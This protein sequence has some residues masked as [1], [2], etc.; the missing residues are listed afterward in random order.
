MEGST[1]KENHNARKKIFH[2]TQNSQYTIRNPKSSMFSAPSSLLPLARRLASLTALACLLLLIALP[3]MAQLNI[4]E[5]D[6]EGND[7][8]RYNRYDFEKYMDKDKSGQRE[9]G[10]TS[11]IRDRIKASPEDLRK[12]G[13]SE[14]F[15]EQL[16]EYNQ[17]LDSLAN[18][19]D[20]LRRKEYEKRMGEKADSLSMD[21]IELL[22]ETQKNELVNKALALPEP[23]VYGHAFFRR[24]VHK[25]FDKNLELDERASENYELGIGDEITVAMW[26]AIDFNEAFL[27]GKNGAIE[28]DLVGRIYLRGLTYENAKKLIKDRFSNT[29]DLSQSNID[30]TLTY[31]RIIS[32][33]FAG[34]LINAGS[35]KLPALTSVFN[36]LVAIDGPN[37]LGSVRNI[38]VRRD[39]KII[40]TFDVYKYLNDPDGQQDFFL[41][42]NDYVVVSTI[43][44]VVNISGEV[45]RPHNYEI[46]NNEGLLKLIEFAGGLK[47]E[48]FTRN[49]NIKRYR[50]NEEVLVDVNL[51]SLLLAK[52]DMELMD[53]DSVFVYRVPVGLRN[54]VEVIGAVNVPGRYEVSKGDR[55]ADVL[56]KTKGVHDEADLGRAYVLRLKENLSKQI[57][58]FNLSK[59]LENDIN[60][61][62][63]LH[64]LDTLQVISRKDFRQ[65]F[66][67][68]VFGA[69]NHPGEFEYAEGLTLKDMIYLAGGM[70][71]EAASERVEV[72]RLVNYED[73][74]GKSKTDRVV[75]KRVVV[76]PDLSVDIQAEIFPLKPFDHIYVRST[77]NFEVQQ[78]IKIYGEVE[79]PGE[80]SLLNKE[81][82][83]LDVIERAGGFTK[84]AFKSGAML[85]RQ[86]DSLGYVILD[87][88]KAE[89]KL[90]SYYNYILTD[91]DSIFIPKVKNLVT[92]TGA[93][94]HFDVM[95]TLLQVSVPYEKNKRAKY[96]IKNYGGGFGRYAKRRRTYVKQPNGNVMKT[97]RTP[98]GKV[99]PKVNSGATVYVDITNRKKNEKVRRERREKRDVSKAFTIFGSSLTT[100]LT[101]ALLIRQFSSN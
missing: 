88:E 33:N 72:T 94:A 5:K 57:I 6:D 93:V 77:P 63:E 90:Q 50:N 53:G 55:V 100:A 30:I 32:A 89:N 51:D 46:K 85:H 59:A 12:L 97:R 10:D 21:D 71:A 78:T 49:L 83:V 44:K 48:A 8:K 61:N 35:Y 18:V 24:N 4:Y 68:K 20:E 86:E 19:K 42:H 73:P 74:T 98:F 11:T 9:E 99:Y 36:A 54:Y 87:L 80:Y 95:D 15:I 96:Y 43:G 62:V 16:Q 40:R 84:F 69:V 1:I 17:M 52:G 81:E 31:S 2:A 37:Q 25:L 28:P 38:F 47:P 22:I 56:L 58:P 92:L 34:E 67:I 65:D 101:L 7:D 91:L 45:K 13:A 60:H 14:D 41:Q 66:S 70:K 23:Y 39:G 82:R 3:S 75:V 64:N 29:Y 26:G 79:Y 76:E 27:I